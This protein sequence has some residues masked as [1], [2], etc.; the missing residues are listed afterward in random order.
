M[1]ESSGNTAVVGTPNT[2]GSQDYGLFQVNV[3][4]NGSR[5]R[6]QPRREMQSTFFSVVIKEQHTK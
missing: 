5:V 3:P 4:H 2:D 1:S 6:N